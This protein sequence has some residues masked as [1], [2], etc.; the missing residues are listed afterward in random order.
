MNKIFPT[1]IAI[2]LLISYHF[3]VAIATIAVIDITLARQLNLCYTAG[4]SIVCL[5]V[6]FTPIMYILH[7]A[8]KTYIF[9]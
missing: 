5:I 6:L 2:L 9:K 7:H 4:Q 3:M 1:T 8:S